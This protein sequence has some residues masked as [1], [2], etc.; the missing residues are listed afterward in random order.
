[1]TEPI[2]RREMIQRGTVLL[3]AGAL[4][5]LAPSGASAKP[6]DS[7]DSTTFVFYTDVHVEPEL[8]ATQGFHQS[9]DTMK[10]IAPDAQFAICGGD[11][12]FDANAVSY[13]RAAQLY[14][15][16]GTQAQ[17]LDLKTYHAMGNHDIFGINAAKSRA[18]SDSLHYGKSLFLE[19]M[20]MAQPYYSFDR[21]GW[22]FI[23]LD[24]VQINPD[25]SWHGLI[26]PAQF[27]WLKQDLE[28][29]SKSAPTLVVAHMPI[30]TAAEMYIEGTTAA[31][32]DTLV[33]A[34]GKDVKELFQPY[35]VKVVLQGHTHIV[36]EINYL[37]TRYITGG[38][39]CGDWWKG[40]RLGVHPEGFMVCHITPAGDFTYQYVPYGWV[41]DKTAAT[42]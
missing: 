20:G 6:K 21:S 16:Y 27:A 30:F 7:K 23:V 40:W 37:N 25:G 13:D 31:P 11:T 34:N 19:R 2:N 29:H 12:V 4:G 28:T 22:H 38:A 17:R 1:M 18:S 32:T 10:K 3:G 15:I 24:T 9:V 26:D 14:D 42:S 36:E 5:V 41:A 8:H 35:N 39:V 33:V